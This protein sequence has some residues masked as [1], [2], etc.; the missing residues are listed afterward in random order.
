MQRELKR[1]TKRF[2]VDVFNFCDSLP[3]HPKGWVIGKQLMRSAS[4]VGA[5]YRAACRAQSRPTFIAKMA[6][7]EEEADESLFW[8]EML[9]DLDMV[10]PGDIR[11][12]IQE[13]RELLAIATAS[14]KTARRNS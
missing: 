1:R 5:N 9:V 2:A 13:A 10:A 4:S 7:V 14:K 3:D 11:S 12:L 6:V 8:M